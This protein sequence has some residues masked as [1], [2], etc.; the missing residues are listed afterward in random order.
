MNYTRCYDSMI[1]L[2]EEA[3]DK[4]G[5]GA[6]LNESKFD[7]L[8][9]ICK[10]TD[11]FIEE[12]ECESYEVSVDEIKKRFTIELVCAEVIFE[13]GRSNEFFSLIQ[14][15]S[16]FSFSKKGTDCICIVMNI[17]NMWR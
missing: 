1:E 3:S 6:M 5:E 17:D 15:L 9:Y 2:V 8:K 4:F 14:L 16:S 11:R 13:N 12:F 7:S 10:V